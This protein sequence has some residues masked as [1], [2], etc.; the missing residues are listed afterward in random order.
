MEFAIEKKFHHS[1]SILLLSFNYILSLTR[2]PHQS[3]RN[4]IDL[5][6]MFVTQMAIVYSKKVC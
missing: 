6:Q 2:I 4:G 1:R 5:T 3:L